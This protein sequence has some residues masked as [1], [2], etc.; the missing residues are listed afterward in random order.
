MRN[1]LIFPVLLPIILI[2]SASGLSARER[3]DEKASPQIEEILAKALEVA[4]RYEGEDLRARFSHKVRTSSE[5]LDGDGKIVS[6]ETTLKNALPIQGF[7]FEELV[8]KDGQ[9]LGPD[10]KRAEQKRKREFIEKIEEGQDP[11]KDER[12]RVFFDQKLVD[13]YEFDLLGIEERGDRESFALSF[14]PKPGDLPVETRMDRALN[15]AEGEIWID[16][17]EYEISYVYFELREK[18]SIWWGLIGSISEMRGKVERTKVAEGVWLPARFELYLN[19]RI[20]FRS[21]HRQETVEWI[22]FLPLDEGREVTSDR[23]KQHLSIPSM[24]Q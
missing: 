13:K 23:G 21:L 5:K 18:I 14:R 11:N 15:K 16:C 12:Q 17:E 4:Q 22:D 1:L 19:G 9:P 20:F 24:T 10:E 2:S 7:I 3:G 6:T 8:E